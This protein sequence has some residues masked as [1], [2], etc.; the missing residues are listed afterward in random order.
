[1]TGLSAW[2]VTSLHYLEIVQYLEIVHYLFDL[3]EVLTS[4]QYS[5]GKH[6]CNA[7]RSATQ[8][9]YHSA[10]SIGIGLLWYMSLTSLP[11]RDATQLTAPLIEC[12]AT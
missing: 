7:Q 2:F 11:E 4:A 10:Q 9:H 3:L 12:G 6:P 1:M 8:I 5:L